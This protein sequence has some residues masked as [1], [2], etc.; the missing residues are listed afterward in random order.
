MKVT[1]LIISAFAAGLCYVAISRLAPDALALAVGIVLG[2]M[3]GI[4]TAL[5]VLAARSD[6]E[7]EIAPPLPELDT[8][9]NLIP[10]VPHKNGRT[11]KTIYLSDE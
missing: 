6:M 4:P 11:D 7:A 8:Y 9:Y 3:A 2:V 5:L 1:L 10:Q